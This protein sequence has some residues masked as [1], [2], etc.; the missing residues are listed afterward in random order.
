MLYMLGYDTFPTEITTDEQR[1]FFLI[2]S[3]MLS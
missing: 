2:S 3:K 1:W